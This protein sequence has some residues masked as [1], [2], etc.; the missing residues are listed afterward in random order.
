MKFRQMSSGRVYREIWHQLDRHPK[1]DTFMFGD[2]LING[3]MKGLEGF[4]DLA[5]TAPLSMRWRGPAIIR[6]EMTR[7]LLHKM[8]AAG[9]YELYYGIESG[10]ENVR[11]LM[12]KMFSTE[13]ALAVLGDT[14]AAGMATH[15]GLIVGYPGETEA[16]MDETIAFVRT[17]ACTI[18]RVTIASFFAGEMRDREADH[19][20]EPITH[21]WYWRSKDGLNTYHVRIERAKRLAR[22]VAD[23]GIDACF[24]NNPGQPIERA[25]DESLGLYANWLQRRDAP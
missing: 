12:N 4:C 5:I 8:R 24:L 16:D 6:P 21:P 3:V 25:C 17:A 14:A 22:A 19:E 10:S 7:P 1:A 9:C 2:S 11:R 15:I 13:V 23:C 20:M 18:T